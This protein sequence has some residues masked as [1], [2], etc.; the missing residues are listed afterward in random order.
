MM[1]IRYLRHQEIDDKAW[2]RCISRSVNRN[3]YAYSWYLNLVCEEWDALVE[4]EYERVFPLP[5]RKKAG[6]H[7][8]YMPPFTQQLGL[9]STKHL[10]PGHVE[11]FLK[12]IP[13][14]FRLVEINLNTI[15]RYDGSAIESSV[16]RNYELELIRDYDD[17][18]SSYSANLKRNLARAEKA[19]LQLNTHLSPGEVIQLFRS[20]RGRNIVTLGDADYRILE[21]LTHSM[22]HQGLGQVTGVTG[23]G[24][25]ILAGLIMAEIPQRSI[26]LFSATERH[27]ENHGALPWLIDQYIRANVP[28]QRILDFEGSNDPGLAR[29]YAGFG[30]KETKY[31]QIRI[32]R[33]PAPFR[34]SL[35]AYRKLR[36]FFR[37]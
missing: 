5:F 30:A 8:V 12:T 10:T 23:P 32:D 27:D 25:R 1:E 6:V 7:Y 11:A 18:R 31:Q 4:G 13:K 16:R 35:S 22:L 37:A 29:F 3:L 34:M 15:N 21:R 14:H 19:G 20:N 33:L 24:N 9:F 28:R 36:G 17:L 2:D 26:L